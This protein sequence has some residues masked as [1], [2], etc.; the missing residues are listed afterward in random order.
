M[1]IQGLANQCYST[2]FKTT[3]TEDNYGLN[4]SH[5]HV[6]HSLELNSLYLHT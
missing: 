1:A 2:V 5:L 4:G 3:Y 6:Y